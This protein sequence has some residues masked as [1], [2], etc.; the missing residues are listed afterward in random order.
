M[1]P[2]IDSLFMQQLIFAIALIYVQ[3]L[4]LSTRYPP[5]CLYTHD[6]P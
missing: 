2:E 5:L 4:D 1:L 3:N 6:K